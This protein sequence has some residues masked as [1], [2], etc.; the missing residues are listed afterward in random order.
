MSAVANQPELI[1]REGYARLTVELEQLETIRRREVADAL[2]EARADGG[3]VGEGQAVAEA[4]AESA[5]LEHRIEELTAVLAVC[6]IAE[7]P[8]PG[9]VGVGQHVMLR[10]ATAATAMRYPLVG[11]FETDPGAGRIS[12]ESPVGHAIV[13]KCAGDRVEVETPSGD[14]TIEILEVG[15]AA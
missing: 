11:A 4:L 15:D 5:A 3:E 1:T 13:G 14:R 8:T 7:P 2:R 10:L 6:Q 12:I 9:V